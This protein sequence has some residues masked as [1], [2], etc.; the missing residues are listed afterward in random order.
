MLYQL[1]YR[2]RN[3]TVK[4]NTVKKKGVKRRTVKKKAVENGHL[5]GKL[6]TNED[7]ADAI[8]PAMVLRANPKTLRV[9]QVAQNLAKECA[10]LAKGFRGPG[11]FTR[12]DQMVRASLSIASNIAEGCGRGS[13][14]DFR[15]FLLHARG[16]AQETLTQLRVVEPGSEQQRETIRS[17]QSRTIL[18]LKMINRLYRFPPPDR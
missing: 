18:I 10:L 13:I 7:P 14:P 16:S 1:S 3:N 9:M 12:G 17:L 5:C 11:A 6:I 15:R 8:V 2:L 4:A